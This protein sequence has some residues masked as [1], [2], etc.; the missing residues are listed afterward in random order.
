VAYVREK[1]RQAC[2][3]PGET[4]PSGGGEMAHGDVKVSDADSAEK[5]LYQNIGRATM[6]LTTLAAN[7]AEGLRL[8]DVVNATSLGKATIHRVLSGLLAHG[9]IDQDKATGRFF[10]SLKLI[11]WAMAAGDRFGLARIAV[12]ALARLSQKTQDTVYLS[13]RAGDDAVCLDRREG[14]FPIKTLTLRVGDRRPLGVGAGSLAILAFLPDDEVERVIA[15]QGG[16]QARYGIDEMTMRDMIA[17]ARQLGYSVNDERLIRGMSA[18]GV[19]LRRPNGQ[20]FAALSVAAIS[21]RLQIPRRDSIAASLKQE[22]MLLEEELKPI[23][24]QPLTAQ[25]LAASEGV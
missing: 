7:S 6:V 3:S 14:S 17:T 9:L 2:L 13:L 22:A 21:S 18:I 12:N 5:G 24:A 16:D 8:T 4:I 19:P 10:L 15:A 11:S 25:L 1:R 20:P 23:L